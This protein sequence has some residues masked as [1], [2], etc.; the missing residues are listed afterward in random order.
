MLGSLTTTYVCIYVLVHSMKHTFSV[1]FLKGEE[2]SSGA[3]KR[4]C[5]LAGKA[6]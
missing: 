3:K 5:S 6:G 4:V 1:P 2:E